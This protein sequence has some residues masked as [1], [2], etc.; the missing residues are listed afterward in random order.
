MKTFIGGKIQGIRITK[1]SPHYN[2]SVTV[3]KDLL[4]L[5]GMQAY[6]Q[7]QVVNITNGN[8]WMTYLLPGEKGEFVL[9]GA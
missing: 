8:R 6:E 7:V 3:D 5:A 4:Q 9:N 1:K 2:G